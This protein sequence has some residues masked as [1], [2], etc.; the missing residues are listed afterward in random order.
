LAN[1]DW[2]RRLILD[3]DLTP[4]RISP[5]AEDSTKGYLGK[6]TSQVGNWLVS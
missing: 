3:L 2:R 1:H 4:L 5:Q 6:K